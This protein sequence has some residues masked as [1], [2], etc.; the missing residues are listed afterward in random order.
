ML[1]LVS[2]VILLAWMLDIF[3]IFSIMFEAVLIFKVNC[4]SFISDGLNS[5]ILHLI[6]QIFSLWI[7]Q[8]S[9]DTIYCYSFPFVYVI[10]FFSAA[11]F[12]LSL[13]YIFCYL[14]ETFSLRFLSHF[15]FIF[16]DMTCYE[17]QTGLQLASFFLQPPEQLQLELQCVPSCPSSFSLSL[18]SFPHS[19]LFLLFSSIVLLFTE[20]S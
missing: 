8:F 20:L 17:C 10:V 4:I 15:I 9:T 11:G 18:L 5:T 3:C 7:L 6:S 14:V 1:S 19:V 12:H 2:S 13:I 16:W